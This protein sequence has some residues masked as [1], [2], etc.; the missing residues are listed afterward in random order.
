MKLIGV[1]VGPGDP[2]H[3][4]L[5]ALRALQRADRVF[6]PI[7]DTGS[8][9][10]SDVVAPHVPA[11]R[12]EQLLFAMRDD[13]ARA[14]NWDRAGEAI[15]SVLRAGGTAAFATIGDPNL[16][17]TFTYVA[18]TV[19]ALVPDVVVETIPGI[20]ALQDLAAR[21]GTVLAEGDERLALVPWPAGADKLREALDDFDTVVVYKGG[22]HLPRVLETIDRAGRLEESVYGE[23]LGLEHE[24]VAAAA[25]RE[26]RGPYMSTVIVPRRAPHERGAR[27]VPM[28]GEG[29]ERSA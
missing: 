11:E 18:E 20:T 15:A 1:G 26:G 4:T 21:S 9:R 29:G 5:M 2:E 22:R 8:T 6:V 14:G 7:T 10:A 28:P 3:L 27:I 23:Q 25:E 17:S 13:A 16:Y 19:R 24:A 12:I